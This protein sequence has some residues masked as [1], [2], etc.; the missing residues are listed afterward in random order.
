MG[1]KSVD[2]DDKQNLR[3]DIMLFLLMQITIASPGH[4]QNVGTS[5]PLVTIG[6]LKAIFWLP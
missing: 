4:G 3:G 5:N 2:A 6:F 1:I